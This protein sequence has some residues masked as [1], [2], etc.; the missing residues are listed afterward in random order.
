VCK[1]ICSQPYA[2]PDPPPLVKARVSFSDPFTITGVDFTGALYVCATEG[3]NKVYLCLFTCAVSRAIH[4]EVASDLTVKSFLQA[5]RRFAGRRSLPKMLFSDNGSTFL[6]APAEL[7]HLFSSSE[8][9]ES[10]AHKGVEW[11]FIPKCA[12]WFGGFRERLVGL[13]KLVLKKTLGRTY[14]TLE[15]LQTIV[16]IEALLND[17]LLTHVSPDLRDPE[18]ITPAHLLYGKRLTTLPHCGLKLFEL[19]RVDPDYGSVSD[20]RKRVRAQATIVK[21]FWIRWK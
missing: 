6:A 15:S 2:I 17:W 5:F 9:S 10:L 3:E 4:L 19:D 18:P 8:V 20:L 14:A 13:T 1:K 16:E 21:Q 12:P 7:Q 11:R